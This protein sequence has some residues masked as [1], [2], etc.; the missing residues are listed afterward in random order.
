MSSVWSDQW[1]L[2]PTNSTSDSNSCFNDTRSTVLN[3]DQF[4]GVPLVL[5]LDFCVFLVNLSFCHKD[6]FTKFLSRQKKVGIMLYYA[7]FNL[8]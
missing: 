8:L 4:G 6:D 2:A 7:I 1:P 3:G 5:L